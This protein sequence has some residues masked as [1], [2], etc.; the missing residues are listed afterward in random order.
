MSPWEQYVPSSGLSTDSCFHHAIYSLSAN[1]E[2]GSEKDSDFPRVTQ[3]GS[4]NLHVWAKE[5]PFINICRV[6]HKTTGYWHMRWRSP[7]SGAQAGTRAHTK[8]LILLCQENH[9][10]ASRICT[11]F[12]D[13]NK[14]PKA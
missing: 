10:E 6:Y 4:K 3:F 8:S 13:W 5:G 14:N 7:D 9:S 1:E 11:M 2:T 12:L